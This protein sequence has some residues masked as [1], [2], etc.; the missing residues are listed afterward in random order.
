MRR[1]S[2][3]RTRRCPR[4]SSTRR[5]IPVAESRQRGCGRRHGRRGVREAPLPPSSQVRRLRVGAAGLSASRA[6]RRI[7]DALPGGRRGTP[8]A[9]S[10]SPFDADHALDQV[11]RAGL[12]LVVDLRDVLADDPQADHDEAA[13]DQQRD[14]R[15]REAGDRAPLEPP[16]Q[17]LGR[18]GKAEDQ[19]EQSQDRDDAQR[20][21]RERY[22]GRRGEIDQLPQRP[23]APVLPRAPR[24]RTE[25]SRGGSRPNPPGRGRSVASPGVRA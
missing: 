12:D 14:D 25:C 17:R 4:F 10:S 5:R 18:D 23:F 11:R 19:R 8:C 6:L 9:A 15:R 22:D 16:D 21:A 3:P 13:D 24:R 1:P 7:G 20:G 2:W